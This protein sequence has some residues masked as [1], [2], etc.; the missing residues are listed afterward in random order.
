MKGLGI[1]SLTDIAP[2]ARLGAQ[3]QCLRTQRDILDKS[4]EDVWLHGPLDLSRVNRPPNWPNTEAQAMLLAQPQ[5][6]LSQLIHKQKY[7]VSDEETEQPM[8]VATS[9][10]SKPS[11]DVSIDNGAMK[12]F[13]QTFTAQPNSRPDF[14]PA[15]ACQLNC[16]SVAQHSGRFHHLGCGK[17]NAARIKRHNMIVD[18]VV[19]HMKRVRLHNVE[20]EVSQSAADLDDEDG[21]NGKDRP[22]IRFTVLDKEYVADALVTIGSVRLNSDELIPMREALEKSAR[23]KVSKYSSFNV[24]PLILSVD[25]QYHKGFSD[26]IQI[27]VKQ[28]K[29]LNI[30]WSPV[31]FRRDIALALIKGNYMNYLTYGPIS[32]AGN[33]RQ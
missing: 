31:L 19:S 10:F 20:V 32:G 30:H 4:G 12:L 25:G 33:P 9:L 3:I 2:A 15:G 7:P 24:I 28:S 17:T 23:T 5:H 29:G 6:E 22:D 13:F 8:S 14:L 21:A 16:N 27:M 18:T 26:L 11:M 1:T